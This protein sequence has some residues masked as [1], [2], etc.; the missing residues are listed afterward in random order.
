MEYVGKMKSKYIAEGNLI[1]ILL[2]GEEAA[3][4]YRPVLIHKYDIWTI[5]YSN[6]NS[7]VACVSCVLKEPWPTYYHYSNEIGGRC[8][9]HCG[10]VARR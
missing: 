6:G 10:G 2:T 8:G 7:R 4:N 9:G 3:D 5:V 1:G